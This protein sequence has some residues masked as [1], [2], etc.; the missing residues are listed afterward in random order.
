MLVLSRT[1]GQEIAIGN[2]FRI[3]VLEIRGGKARIGIVAPEDVVVD[4]QEIHEKRR[5]K[6]NRRAS[7]VKDRFFFDNA[8]TWPVRPLPRRPG[9]S[10]SRSGEGS[11]RSR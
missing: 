4:R 6:L 7:F 9:S 3:E 2:D 8:S 5:G 10:V 11:A 1:V